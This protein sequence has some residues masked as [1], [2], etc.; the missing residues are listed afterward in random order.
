MELE[1]K[2]N[3]KHIKKT[4]RRKYAYIELVKQPIAT[5]VKTKNLFRPIT[6]KVRQNY[7]MTLQSYYRTVS[8]YKNEICKKASSINYQSTSLKPVYNL[9]AKYNKWVYSVGRFEYDPTPTNIRLLRKIR[10]LQKR[11]G[12]CFD[13]AENKITANFEVAVNKLNSKKDKVR[14][15][16]TAF[17]TNPGTVNS[18][19]AIENVHKEFLTQSSILNSF[20]GTQTPKTI[21]LIEKGKQIINDEYWY[22]KIDD[23]DKCRQEY[24]DYRVKVP[25][26]KEFSAVPKR[27]GLNSGNYNVAIITKKLTS[28]IAGLKTTL[29]RK[30]VFSSGYRNPKYQ[31]DKKYG[32]PTSRHCYGD[33]V[34]V[35]IMSNTDKEWRQVAELV[36]KSTPKPSWV[37]PL[38]KSGNQHLHADWGPKRK[39]GSSY[40]E[41]MKQKP[42][43]KP[44]KFKKY[45]KISRELLDA[46]LAETPTERVRLWLEK[47]KNEI[48]AAEKKFSIDRR[49]IAGAIAWEAL[50]NPIVGSTSIW[51]PGKVHSINTRNPLKSSNAQLVEEWG[52]LPKRN[53]LQRHE[54]LKDPRWAI[55]YIA[56]ITNE[57][58]KITE[59]FP[60]RN[61]RNKPEILATLYNAW[62][63]D[64]WRERLS[65]KPPSK[66]MKFNE[67]YMGEWM[68]YPE[69]LR[70]LESAVGTSTTKNTGYT[71]DNN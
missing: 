8:Y 56:A 26:R 39:P 61:V 45:E 20:F 66:K 15:S 2:K 51:G 32:K 49:V 28:G 23:I 52:I 30:Y 53:V 36:C 1:L 67:G 27:T 41:M 19:K 50:E 22:S 63:F 24:I 57:L 16:R 68:S 3:S 58:A 29:R 7:G 18:L 59:S 13:C 5:I 11:L 47:Y 25:K 4:Q 62:D 31:V 60:G 33:A 12:D 37:E 21:S 54:I 17:E 14:N 40:C 46:P 42:M 34:D 65:K 55:K 64:D 69:N 44:I 35:D 48:I 6:K 71:D 10:E 70:Y 38:S 43:P 9:T